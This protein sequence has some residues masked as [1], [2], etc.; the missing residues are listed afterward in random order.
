MTK[1]FLEQFF[2]KGWH[3]I[4]VKHSTYK[5]HAIPLTQKSIEEKADIIVACGGD[6]S[7]NE[8]ASCLIGTSIPLGIVPLGSGNGLASN[9]NIPKNLRN[10]LEIIRNANA[11]WIDVGDINHTYFF[12]NTGIGFDASVIRNYESSNRRTLLGYL[13]ACLSSFRE[14]KQHQNV[15]I[16]IN[17]LNILIDPFIIFVSN[18]NEMGYRLSLTPKASLQDGLLDVLIISKIGKAKMIWLGLLILFN[19]PYLLKEAKSFQT[20]RIELYT[21]NGANLNTQIDGEVHS[22]KNGIISIRI[23]EGALKV[24]VP[25][26]HHIGE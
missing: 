10:S 5:K 11:V 6:G 18:S 8:V 20:Q 9:L 17:G 19:R 14:L 7:I 16:K 23:I 21:V 22:V 4:T 1:E 26:D 25:L 24:I 3:H 12:S 13:G 2:V 15:K